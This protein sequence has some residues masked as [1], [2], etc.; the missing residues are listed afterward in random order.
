MNNIIVRRRRRKRLGNS[1][2]ADG[3]WI[4]RVVWKVEAGWERD[5]ERAAVGPSWASETNERVALVS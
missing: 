5:A 4:T 2:D 3:F 1:V